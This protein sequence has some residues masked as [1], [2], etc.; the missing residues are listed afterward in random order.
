MDI[1]RYNYLDNIK[2]AL[3]VL[4]IVGIIPLDELSETYTPISTA[5]EALM[6]T[7][8]STIIAIIAVIALISMANAAILTTTRYPFAMSRDQLMPKWL[9]EINPRFSTPH[10]SILLTGIIMVFLIF[11][12]DIKKTL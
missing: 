2:W 12:Y 1:K 5:A 3:V 7:T 9:L 11:L 8:G 4:V 6:G 10:N